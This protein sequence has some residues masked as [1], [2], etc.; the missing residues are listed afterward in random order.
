[1][2]YVVGFVKFT[3]DVRNLMVVRA[4]LVVST[5]TMVFN[6]QIGHCLHCFAE[7]RPTKETEPA[8]KVAVAGENWCLSSDKSTGAV[9]ASA[10]LILPGTGLG[11]VSSIRLAF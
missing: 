11:C 5:T 6:C 7:T 1:M 8:H 9:G 3:G 10:G 4:V 2:I